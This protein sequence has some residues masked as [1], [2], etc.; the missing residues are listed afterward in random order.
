[1]NEHPNGA[2]ARGQ[3]LTEQQLS[4]RLDGLSVPEGAASHLDR[5]QACRRALSRLQAQAA[6]LRL[7]ARCHGLAHGESSEGWLIDVQRDGQLDLDMFGDDVLDAGLFDQW[8]DSELSRRPSPRQCLHTDGAGAN[9]GPE[10]EA[11]VGR[12]GPSGRDA[13]NGHPDEAGISPVGGPASDHDE[14]D[15]ANTFPRG[16]V[17]GAARDA[18]WGCAAQLLH[19]LFRAVARLDDR[20]CEPGQSTPQNCSLAPRVRRLGVA[21]SV[22]RV[23]DD[24]TSLSRRLAGLGVH[25]DISDLPRRAPSPESARAAAGKVLAALRRIAPRTPR[26]L[27]VEAI[28]L[29]DSRSSARGHA[30]RAAIRVFQRML[31]RCHS[32]TSDVSPTSSPSVSRGDLDPSL[33]PCLRDNLALSLRRAADLSATTA[34]TRRAKQTTDKL[35]PSDASQRVA[36]PA[37]RSEPRIGHQPMAAPSFL[38]SL[39]PR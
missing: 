30:C 3:H 5:C 20:Q 18:A 12:H 6:A 17:L 21:R 7:L 25:L 8:L 38:D 15:T 1:M 10:A 16:R 29:V 2:S 39:A 33:M 34:T 22:E 11:P 24:L 35:A 14:F 28:W 9:R 36:R 19:E 13:V 32:S 4:D 23:S 31:H 27:L 26:L 37:A